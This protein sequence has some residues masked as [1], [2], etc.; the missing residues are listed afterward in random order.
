MV[1]Y[2]TSDQWSEFMNILS[3]GTKVRHAHLYIE[4]VLHPGT[5]E[6]I[7]EA[8]LEKNNIDYKGKKGLLSHGKGYTNIYYIQPKDMCHFEIMSVYNPDIVIEPMS[9]KK[10]REGQ[11]IDYWD[12]DFMQNFYKKISF[13]AMGKEER[14]KVEQYFQSDG[15]KQAYVTMAYSD[16]NVHSHCIVETSLHPEEI[17]PIG[18]EAIESRGWEVDRAVSVVFSMRG[19]DIGK[20]TYLLSK[21]I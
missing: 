11:T 5:L 4:S 12:D 8:Y 7:A 1:D 15:W 19:Y 14:K 18:E 9:S 21:P 13:K 10:T 16:E 20:I 2:L 3:R 6:K 17:L